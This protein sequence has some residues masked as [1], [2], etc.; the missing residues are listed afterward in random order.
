MAT[1]SERLKELRKEKRLTVEQL[2]DKLGSAKSTISRYEN[3]K[4]EPKKDFLEMLSSFFDV[5]IS[6]LL[7]E[8]DIKKPNFEEKIKKDKIDE[9]EED[10]KILFDKLKGLTPKDRNKIIKIIE[11]FEKENE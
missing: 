4:R 6:Y 1:F 11:M 5:S 3:G 7:G 2:A 8:T 9:L 10:N